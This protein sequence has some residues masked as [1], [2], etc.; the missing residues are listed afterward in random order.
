VD[1]AISENTTTSRGGGAPIPARLHNAFQ[2]NWSDF[3]GESRFHLPQ[4]IGRRSFPVRHSNCA[5]G[6]TA[7]AM[8][9]FGTGT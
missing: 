9:A 7:C 3:F 2:Q 8:N 5:P 4:V 6:G 1:H